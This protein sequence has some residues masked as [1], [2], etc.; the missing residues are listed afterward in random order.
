MA[1]EIYDLYRK[2]AEELRSDLV[3]FF[4]AHIEP[5]E[6]DGET[7]WRT[8]TAGQKL[9]KLNLN[10]KLAY[11]LYTQVEREGSTPQY[12]FV[13]QT[14]G[15]NEA[16]SV[17]GVLPPKMENNLGEVLYAIRKLDL[18]IEDENK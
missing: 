2:C 3:V 7:H 4:M 16:R 5:Y 15:K 1:V 12:Y 8:K 9:T 11:N 6:A 14:S 17:E 10:S 13:T 18:G